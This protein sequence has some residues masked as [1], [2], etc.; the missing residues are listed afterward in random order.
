MGRSDTAGE[1]RF[2][3]V[4]KCLTRE[5][6]RLVDEKDAFTAFQREIEQIKPAPAGSI[7]ET[8]STRRATASGRPEFVRVQNAYESTVMAVSHYTEDYGDTYRDSLS[9]EF[10][11]EIAALLTEGTMFDSRCKHILL[12]AIAD[13][14]QRRKLLLEV[15]RQEEES[16]ATAREQLAPIR[17]EIA[18]IESEPFGDCTFG[19]L[20]A[21]YSRLGVLEQH[22]ADCLET[23]QCALNKQRDE[24]AWQIDAPD[25]PIYLYRTLDVDYPVLASIADISDRIESCRNEIEAEMYRQ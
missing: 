9:E 18:E 19:S 22:C 16:V 23:R 21:L 2:E 14:L 11:P 8:V 7:P 6:Q 15:T 17:D 20:E 5:C 25:F 1:T 10:G 4:E 24:F 3:A 12:S 13:A